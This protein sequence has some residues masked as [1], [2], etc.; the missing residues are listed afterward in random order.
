MN[1]TQEKEFLN[2]ALNVKGMITKLESSSKIWRK[3]NEKRKQKTN[4]IWK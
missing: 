4:R 2:N 3:E 1:G